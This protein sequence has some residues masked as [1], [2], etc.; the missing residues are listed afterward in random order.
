MLASG[1]V[2]G[3]FGWFTNQGT[4]L[5]TKGIDIEYTTLHDLGDPTYPVSFFATEESLSRQKDVLTRF[6]RAQQKAWKWYADNPEAVA[7]MTVETYGPKGLDIAQQTAEAKLTGPLITMG[8][9][10][11]NSVLW[12]DRPFFEH[13]ISLGKEAG[14]IQG[15]V[16]VDDVM[17]QDIVKAANGRA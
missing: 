1:Q 11:K 16:R 15:E 14:L 6:V 7:K 17:T 9:A 10:S 2:D 4:M 12:I 5:T 13:G 8:D 3:Y